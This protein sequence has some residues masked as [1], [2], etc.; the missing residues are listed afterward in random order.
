MKAEPG[1]QF[2]D[3]AA[4]NIIVADDA[5]QRGSEQPEPADLFFFL[6][7]VASFLASK[8]LPT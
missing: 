2:I 4:G 3:S 1:Q 5:G 7:D 6:R 8:D